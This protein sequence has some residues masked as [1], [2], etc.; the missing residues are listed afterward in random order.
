LKKKEENMMQPPQSG[1]QIGYGRGWFLLVCA[2]L[3][4]SLFWM[5]LPFLSAQVAPAEIKDRQLKLLQQANLKKLIELKQAIAKLSFPYPLLVSRYAGLDPAEQAASDQRGLEFVNFK[6]RTVLKVT[7]N[8]NAAYN[9]DLLTANE[10]ASHVFEDVVR[11]ILR[12]IPAYFQ[13]NDS[14][15]AVGFEISYHVRRKAR[16]YSYEGKENFVVVM[17]RED[18]LNFAKVAK[19]NESQEVLKR[20]EIYLNG[21][22]FGLMLG[23]R[24]AQEVEARADSSVS[25]ALLA[26]VRPAVPSTLKSNPPSP[27]YRT[28]TLSS[29]A[30]D[31]GPE[32]STPTTEIASRSDVE[33]LQTKHQAQLDALGKD[34]AERFHLVDYAPPSFVIFQNKTYL[35]LTLRNPARFDRDSTSI[36]KRAAQSF[37]LFL[38]P[39]LKALLDKLPATNDFTGLDITILNDLSS[40]D[41]HSSEALELVF[42]LQLLRQFVEAQVTNQDLINRSIVLV[43]G[44]RIALNLQLVE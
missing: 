38:A 36:Y 19:D 10:R 32:V 33:A 17:G 20:S 15:G 8:Y 14:F 34:G 25:P 4:M 42:P 22:E 18:A 35:Q 39:Q 27:N 44:V 23:Q 9:A 6:G 13:G 3:G 29:T 21:K 7:G 2:L 5:Q 1:E 26:S 41:T 37:D 40:K 11:P 30:N 43:N 28:L 12:V 16:D 24:D 31:A